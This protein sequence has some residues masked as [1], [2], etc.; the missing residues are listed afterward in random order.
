MNPVRVAEAM[1]Y[2]GLAV[3]GWALYEIAGAVV[4]A[5]VVGTEVSLLGVIGLWMLRDAG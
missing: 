5:L 4:A 1:V 3:Q 2:G